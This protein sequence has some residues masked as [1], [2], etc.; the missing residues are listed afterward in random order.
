MKALVLLSGGL[1]S[2]ACLFFHRSRGDEV[3]ALYVDYGQPAAIPESRAATSVARRFGAQLE[4]VTLRTPQIRTNREV[5]G[6]NAALLS[7]AL[8]DWAPDPGGVTIGV[9]AGTSYSDCTPA[10]V[11]AMQQ[12]FDIY[13]DGSVRVLAPFVN[14]RKEEVYAQIRQDP[15]LIRMC[16]VCDLGSEP[17]CGT[18][19]SCSDAR[20]VGA[21]S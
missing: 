18:C 5:P 16:Y 4:V 10:F 17:E 9:H 13:R 19:P 6:R 20:R 3:A 21:R 12:V 14:W 2:A 15:D 11:D 7:I 8:L 1:D